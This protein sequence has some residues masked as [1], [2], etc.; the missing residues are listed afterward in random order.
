MVCHKSAVAITNMIVAAACH[1][2][3]QRRVQEELDMVFGKDRCKSQRFDR[4]LDG[5]GCL[6]TLH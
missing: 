3:A 6:T 4:P 1:P 5:H 2:D